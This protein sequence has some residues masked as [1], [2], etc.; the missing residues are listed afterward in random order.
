[1]ISNNYV[2]SFLEMWQFECLGWE[3]DFKQLCFEVFFNVAI[4]VIFQW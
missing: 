1:M 4:S 3:Y 2:L